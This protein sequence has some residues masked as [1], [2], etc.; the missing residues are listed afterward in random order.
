MGS[1]RI[2]FD[3]KSS[4]CRPCLFLYKKSYWCSCSCFRRLSGLQNFTPLLIRARY[5]SARVEGL[6]AAVLMK[7]VVPE[8]RVLFFLGSLGSIMCICK[9]RRHIQ[10]SLKVDAFC[11]RVC[12]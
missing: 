11:I 9:K 7:L 12:R 3:A 2:R 6:L 4:G 1:D 8:S 10:R 5:L